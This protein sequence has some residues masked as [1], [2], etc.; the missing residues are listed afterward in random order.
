MII[1]KKLIHVRNK[2]NDWK[3]SELPPELLKRNK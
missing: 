1:K 3:G 2:K